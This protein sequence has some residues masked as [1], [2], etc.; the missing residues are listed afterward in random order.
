[1]KLVRRIAP[2]IYLV[3]KH[4]TTVNGVYYYNRKYPEELRS[5]FGG[6]VRKKVSLRTRDEAVAAR[7]AAKMAAADDALWKAMRGNPDLPIPELR[8]AATALLSE[9]APTE[10]QETHPD[11]PGEVRTWTKPAVLAELL[12]ADG[13]PLLG[14]D[15]HQEANRVLK[16]G[17]AIP[18]LSEALEVYLK[19]HPNRDNKH[20]ERVAR[21][22]VDLVISKL[23]DRPMD[24]YSRSEVTEW[25]D[26]LLKTTKTAT[27]KRRLGSIKAVFNK[28]CAEF[29]LSLV[30]PFAG[31][32]IHGDGLDSEERLPFTTEELIAIR[33]GV[34]SADDDIRWIIGLLVETGA[35]AGEVIGLRSA[36]LKLDAPIPHVQFR[37]HQKLGRRLKNRN[38]ERDV[39]LVGVSL[40]SAQRSLQASP[41]G[42]LFPRYASD[43]N[44]R[45]TSAENTHN[46]W[47]KGLT[48]KTSHSF[49]HTL[50]D[51]LRDSGCPEDAAKQMVGHGARTITRGYGKGYSLEKLRDYLDAAK[52]PDG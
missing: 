18:L 42:W 22:G 6:K 44:I 26:D 31:L 47:L 5:R 49:R 29:Q 27:F 8:K 45:A 1:M 43:G 39:P 46:K 28:G 25:R 4:L 51:R 41:K 2:G 20:S 24:T 40:W 34:R 13:N 30:N 11:Y 19:E 48:G 21:L 14:T 9:Y 17:R 33:S 15:I 35:R 37:W 10:W 23:G 3:S 32:T 38:S 12:E 52:L 36:D 7:E 50:L 16:G